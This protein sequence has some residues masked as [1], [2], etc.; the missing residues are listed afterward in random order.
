[1]I[2][3]DTN[4]VAYLVI[5]G[6]FTEAATDALRVDPEWVAPSQ[7]FYELLNLLSTYTR[8]KR[9]T[10][11][12]AV[13]AYRRARSVVHEMPFESDAR[14]VLELSCGSRLAAY[15]CVFVAAAMSSDLPLVTFDR[16]LREAYP[17]TAILP[18]EIAQWFARRNERRSQ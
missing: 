11:D 12:Q 9:L 7:L 5:N 15:D 3:A 2:V 10:I 1:V 6:E 18:S 16:Q 14:V 13:D 8:Q 17:A 4:L